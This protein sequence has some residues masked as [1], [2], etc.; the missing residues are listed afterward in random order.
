ME[1]V[2]LEQML[3]AR[4]KRAVLQQEMLYKHRLPLVSFTMNIAGPIKYSKDI[5]AVFYG[6][7]QELR[8][9]L[10][11]DAIKECRHTIE[12]T[13]CELLLAVDMNAQE[14]KRI[15]TKIEEDTPYGRLF[16]MDVLDVDGKKLERLTERC[17]LVCGKGGRSCAAGRVHSVEELQEKT[18]QLIAEFF[19]F[20]AAKKLASHVVL[21]LLSE[22]AATPKPGL[23]DRNNSGSHSDM[24]FDMFKRSAQALHPYF[25][26]CFHIGR[27][28][29]STTTEE[30]FSQLQQ[31][32]IAAEETMYAT[33][34]GV[35]THKGA[36]Y[37]FGVLCGAMGRLWND[38][39]QTPT[40]QELSATCA[41][42]GYHGLKN[43]KNSGTTA[44][45]ECYRTYGFQGVR[46][47]AASGFS[48][49]I[50]FAL[51]ILQNKAYWQNAPY[52]TADCTALLHLIANVKD[53]TL[54]HRGGEEGAA[55]AAAYAQSLLRTSPIPTQ[56][57]LY[58]MDAEFIKRNLSPGGCADLLA[59]AL[60]FSDLE[61]VN[62]SIT[63]LC[64]F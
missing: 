60:F 26:Q 27:N 21:C 28:T 1:H 37:L 34:N 64:E 5:Q 45:L 25:V 22:A 43:L 57:Q 41:E 51:P 42:I 35:N 20:N 2:T 18:K 44:G 62:Y 61:N 30:T 9:A 50:Q 17:C 36:I 39:K 7:Y 10:P 31:A 52:A 15:C 38:S 40:V 23:V 33:T 32:G 8:S 4:E 63:P 49:V 3:A 12:N 47:E 29:K 46:G 14:L 54:Y 53:T 6:G 24:D 55:F 56:A 19:A 11:E 58:A 48:S 16:D 13:G 59:V